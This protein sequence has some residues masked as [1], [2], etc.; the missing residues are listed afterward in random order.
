MISFFFSRGFVL[1]CVRRKFGARF[2]AMATLGQ[3]KRAVEVKMKICM[4]DDTMT[5]LFDGLFR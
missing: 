2:N 4:A 3:E 1:I 5:N